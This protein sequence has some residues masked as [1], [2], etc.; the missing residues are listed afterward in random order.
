MVRPKKDPQD[1][2]TRIIFWRVTELEFQYLHNEASKFSN[3]KYRVSLYV[4]SKVFRNYLQQLPGDQLVAS[5]Q[6]VVDA[7]SESNNLF[8]D[9]VKYIEVAHLK[10]NIETSC[11]EEMTTLIVDNSKEMRR[12]QKLLVEAL[13]KATIE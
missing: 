6:S 4:Y 11:F 1:K 13:R 12:L 3:S 10:G 2:K 5:I 9:C 8:S 7:I